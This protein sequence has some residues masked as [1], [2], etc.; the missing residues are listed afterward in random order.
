MIR[1]R[2]VRTRLTILYSTVFLVCGAALLGITY[3][4]VEHSTGA[5]T[6]FSAH[7]HPARATIFHRNISAATS[8]RVGDPPPLSPQLRSLVSQIQANELHQLFL[9]SGIT[10]IIMALVA[11]AFGH[12][13]AG[14]SLRPLRSITATARGISV[15]NLHERLALSGPQDELKDLGDTFDELLARLEAS[16]ASQRQFVANASHELRSPVTRLRLLAEVAATDQDATIETLQAAYKRV[17]AASEHQESLIDALL[18]LAKSQGEIVDR[19]SFDLAEVALTALSLREHEPDSPQVSVETRL[20]T[21]TV[22]GDHRLVERLITNLIDNAV[23]YNVANGHV[24]VATGH[25]DQGS[26]FSVRNDGIAIAASEL[27]RLFQPFQR[28][29]AG[30]GHHKSGHGLGLSIVDAIAHAHGAEIAAHPQPQGGLHIEVRF[31]TS[32]DP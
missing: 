20:R 1:H 26:Y 3:L 11:V 29:E 5:V 17:V 14:R 9:K 24:L 21:A 25:D 4:L 10:L 2:T 30:R 28:L 22:N 8:N 18:T 6:F 27:D 16:F 15:A 7:A 31:P 13:L 19:E 32:V 23:R 12:L